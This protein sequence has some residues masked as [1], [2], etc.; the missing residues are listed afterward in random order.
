[1]FPPFLL[2]NSEMTRLTREYDWG[3]HP[4]GPIY[5]WPESL[6]TSIGIL[7]NNKFPMFLFWSDEL[8]CFYNDAYRPSLGDGT[9][10]HPAI[11]G[12]RGKDAWPEVWN[13]IGS[14]LEQVMQ[15]GEA[16]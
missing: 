13:V 4:L 15:G 1:M 3:S 11:L 14:Q 7:L 5:D 9:G 6:L 10:K 16:T 12:I 8:Y 2:A